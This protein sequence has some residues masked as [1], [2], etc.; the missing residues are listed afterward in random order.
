MGR[1]RHALQSSV[2][3]FESAK[4]LL[5]YGFQLLSL[6][7]RAGRRHPPVPVV[8]G[9]RGE[10]VTPV[11]QATR[12]SCWKKA[13][14]QR[15]SGRPWR[16]TASGIRAPVAAGQQLGRM[17]KS[18]SATVSSPASDGHAGRAAA[19]PATAP[20]TDASV[21][22]DVRS[23]AAA[24]PFPAGAAR[25]SA[26]GS[27][28]PAYQHDRD[29]RDAVFRLGRDRRVVGKA[30]V[31]QGFGR[32]KAV[33][34]ARYATRPRSAPS[35]RARQADEQWPACSIASLK[36]VVPSSKKRT[37]CSCYDELAV[38]AVSIR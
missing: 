12:R 11:P 13:R 8:L 24:P 4:A 15:R 21:S 37:A 1:G 2:D 30:V 36:G 5:S 16:R 14:A 32:F 18:L 20:R 31:E 33:D 28:I 7:R 6:I 23:A 19:R 3:R 9:A 26:A 34:R 25:R 29:G 17:T 27:R 10:F 38:H 35:L 22:T